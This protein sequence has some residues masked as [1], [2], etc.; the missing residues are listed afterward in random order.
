MDKYSAHMYIY[1]LY[2]HIYYVHFF[3]LMGTILY[4]IYKGDGYRRRGHPKGIINGAGTIWH[5]SFTVLL[6]S[7]LQMSPPPSSSL[8]V[9]VTGLATFFFFLDIIIYCILRS[10]INLCLEGDCF[11]YI[12]IYTFRKTHREDTDPVTFPLSVSIISCRTFFLYFLSLPSLSLSFSL[13]FCS[14]RCLA[15]WIKNGGGN[16]EGEKKRRKKDITRNIKNKR[17]GERRPG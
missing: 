17:E 8:S 15:R 9:S 5:S 12:Y 14:S 4:I 11:I 6:P 16:A 2:T 10:L 1:N 7:L 13:C 3:T